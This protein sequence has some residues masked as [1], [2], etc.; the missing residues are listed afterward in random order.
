L[1]QHVKPW[2]CASFDATC[3]PITE[4]FEIF[5]SVF[6][7]R[8]FTETAEDRLGGVA[9]E[10][11]KCGLRSRGPYP[12]ATSDDLENTA[13]LAPRAFSLKCQYSSALPEG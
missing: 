4:L 13:S 5:D 10:F 3:L 1:W 8:K 12:S 6:G 7:S 9:G 2:D 11:L